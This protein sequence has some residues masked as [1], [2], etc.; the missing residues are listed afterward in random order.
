MLWGIVNYI[1]T[2]H[3]WLPLLVLIPVHAVR[4]VCAY[5]R[6]RLGMLLGIADTRSHHARVEN[7]QAQ[8]KA[9]KASGSEVP[10]CTSRN[11]Y[12]SIT[13]Q[14]Q[15][16]KERMYQI[17]VNLPHILGLD[18][19][20]KVV[21]VEPMVTIGQVNDWLIA[22]GWT[23]PVVP[24]IADLTI[25]GLVMGGGIETTSVRYGL[26]Q[27]ICL[28]YEMVLPDGSVTVCSKD[29]NKEL[30][31]SIP[32]SYGTT[33]FLTAVEMQVIPFLP[34]VKL[35]Y[36]PV[37]S[38]DQAVDV[39]QKSVDNKSVDSVEGILFS[40]NEGLIMR[41]TFVKD[42]EPRRLNCIGWWYKPW[43]HKHCQTFCRERKIDRVEYIPTREF[44]HRHYRSSFWLIDFL[45][46]FG[47][48]PLFRYLVGWMLPPPH[49]LVKRVMSLVPKPA[50]DEL[51]IQDF[52]FQMRDMKE[53]LRMV[54]NDAGVYPLWLCPAI[55]PVPESIQDLVYFDKTAVHVDVGIYGWAKKPNFDRV[56]V[57]RK[58]ERFAIDHKGYVAFY[59]ETQLTKEELLEMMDLKTYDKV[60][61]DNNC[62]KA[63]PHMY[64]KISNVGRK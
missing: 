45:V 16:Y 37:T 28:S 11:K 44:F 31:A 63:F 32:F 2:E 24:E 12:D 49:G 41:G 13:I 19:E 17:N 34:Y 64:E 14:N 40:A 54:D 38:L 6:L 51:V 29:V 56:G 4:S 47:H 46:P 30:Y 52:I 60:R 5:C 48:H 50:L 39:L 33:G 3:Q 9:W 18:T 8:V 35:E 43:F 7:V 62:E 42:I 22:K 20:R 59:A 55:H 36:E 53:A 58:W 15:V 10:M 61:K 27:Y 25:G 57:Q 1:A 21:R 23:L 26:F